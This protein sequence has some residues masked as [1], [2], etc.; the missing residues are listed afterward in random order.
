[1]QGCLSRSP[2]PSSEHDDRACL[3]SQLLLQLR[4]EHGVVCHSLLDSQQPHL[5]NV[6]GILAKRKG[7]AI[8]PLQETYSKDKVHYQPM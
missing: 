8:V 3:G 7:F 6:E 2:L 5:R 4:D 1:M